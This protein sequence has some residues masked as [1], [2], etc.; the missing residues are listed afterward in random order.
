[1]ETIKLAIRFSHLLAACFALVTILKADRRLWSWRQ[2]PLDETRRRY[3]GRTAHRVTQLLILL[4]GTGLMLVVLGYSE[5]GMAYLANPKLWTKFSVVALLSVNGYLLHRVAFPLISV[6]LPLT[7]LPLQERLTVAV[8]GA[9]SMTSWLFA[10]W[11]G[12]AREWNQREPYTQLMGLYLLLLI[13]AA[14]GAMAT[15]A[16][17]ESG[18]SGLL[19]RFNNR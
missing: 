11:L 12:I 16:L 19:G 18:V 13:A 14:G 6:R 17:F 15:F 1:M 5:H 10:A 8:L 7:G 3:L 2:R 9:V 4:W